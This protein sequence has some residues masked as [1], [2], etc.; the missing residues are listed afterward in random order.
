MPCSARNFPANRR[1]RASRQTG[2]RPFAI[3]SA[4]GLVAAQLMGRNNRL[5]LPRLDGV[6]AEHH[7]VV[8]AQRL[9][10][11]AAN[12]V[13]LNI[14]PANLWKKAKH[15]PITFVQL[16]L[17][18]W[19]K[20]HGGEAIQRR[21]TYHAALTSCVDEFAQEDKQKDNRLYLTL[22]PESAGYM[23]LGPTFQVL[24]TIDGRLPRTF[25][26]LF[27]GGLS[28]WVRVYDYRD[29]EE[30]AEMYREMSAGEPNP[31]EYEFPDVAGCLPASMKEEPLEKEDLSRLRATLGSALAGQLLD[32]AV[33]I[34]RISD[35]AERPALS[36]DV[37][38]ELFN[39]NPPVPGLLAV[40]SPYDAVEAC[41][42][43]E[44]EYA[45]ETTPEP[46]LIIPIEPNDARSVRTAFRIFG[47]VCDVLAATTRLLEK[48]PGNTEGVVTS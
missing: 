15:D 26:D 7:L 48:M 16:T 17:A 46:N 23:V 9:I 28:K 25:F 41:F 36:E 22:D 44:A 34:D 30:R 4:T 10:P 13:S 47:V 45:L 19:I 20:A 18:D 2:V 32:H 27:V 33:E 43:E 1:R 8:D 42:E 14:A 35:R 39:A 6:P 5:T 38:A 37:R 21:F 29:A 40:F 11:L 3:S 24:E 31:D 12:L